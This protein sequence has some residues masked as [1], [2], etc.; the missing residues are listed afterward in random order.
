MCQLL[1]VGADLGSQKGFPEEPG[2]VP[3]D[4]EMHSAG[5]MQ[6]FV[7][8]APSGCSVRRC[9]CQWHRRVRPAGTIPRHCNTPETSGLHIGGVLARHRLVPAASFI[10]ATQ[11]AWGWRTVQ[12][13]LVDDNS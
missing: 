12:S 6:G 8:G 11:R 10:R 1:Q 7:V 3:V 13:E 5:R 9:A 2:V 4:N